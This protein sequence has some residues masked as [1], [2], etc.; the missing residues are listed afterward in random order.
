MNEETLARSGGAQVGIAVAIL[1]ALVI[2]AEAGSSSPTPQ[3]EPVGPSPEHPD[4]GT[5]G[6]SDAGTG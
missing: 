5:R 1:V 2:L 4:G 3:P 6:G